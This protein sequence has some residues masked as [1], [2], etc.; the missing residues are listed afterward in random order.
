MSDAE[1]MKVYAGAAERYAAG[2]ARKKD[3]EQADDLAAFCALL[4]PGGRVL[5]MGCGPGHWAATFVEAGYAV[6][7]TDASPEMADLAAKRYDIAVRVEPFEALNATEI[8]DGIWCNF[9]LLHAPRAEFPGHLAR[10]RRALKPGG[11]LHLGM[12]LG[13]G[14]GRDRLGRFYAYYG[15]DELVKLLE[16]AGFSV[17]H[18]RRGNGEGLAGG[19]ETF[20]CLTAHA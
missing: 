12:K 16:S 13:T 4:P 7:A 11:A 15:E 17:T 8:Y 9:S 18:R 14:E 20:C 3:I 1:T 10:L 5:D 19:V 2:F 6:E